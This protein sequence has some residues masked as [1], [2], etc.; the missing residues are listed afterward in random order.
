MANLAVRLMLEA[1]AAAKRSRASNKVRSGS[2]S[3]EGR[4]ML[5]A[6][7]ILAAKP[8]VLAALLLAPGFVLGE[9]PAWAR[10][11]EEPLRMVQAATEPARPAV[12][13]V[14]S[15]AGARGV[16]LVTHLS[17]TLMVRQADGMTRALSVASAIH[18]GDVLTTQEDTYARIKFVDSAEVVMRPTSQIKI[19]NYHYEEAR[20]ESDS[21]LL[22]LVKGGLRKVTGL[23][24]KRNRDSV[25]VATVTA[26][27]G[28]RGTHFGALF[29][30]DDCGRIPVPAGRL[31]ENGLHVDVADGAISLRNQGGAQVINAGQFGYVRDAVTAPVIVPPSQGIQVTMPA[32]IA[33]NNTAGRT[34]GTART[35]DQCTISTH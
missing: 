10:I 11:D 13:P 4:A 30:Q 31:L 14:A 32:A 24:G 35:D 5:S 22:S 23:I 28:I 8:L 15:G 7:S 19:N 9:E 6:R 1:K 25:S 17:G 21:V 27:I 3:R 16:G 34:V 20:P 2:N 18:E 29:C 12:T 33:H 26:T